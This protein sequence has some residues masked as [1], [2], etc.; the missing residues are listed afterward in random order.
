[1]KTNYSY[2]IGERVLLD[3]IGNGEFYDPYNASMELK[4][5]SNTIVDMIERLEEKGCIERHKREIHLTEIGEK[6]RLPKDIINLEVEDLELTEKRSYT[7]E[8]KLYIPMKES[9]FG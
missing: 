5:S 9:I 6:F 4:C 8:D 1:M 2:S 7:W 3:I